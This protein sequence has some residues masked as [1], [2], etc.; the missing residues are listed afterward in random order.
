MKTLVLDKPATAELF[1]IR[2]LQGA[3]FQDPLY[4]GHSWG[5]KHPWKGTAEQAV[6]IA[7]CY[8]HPCEILTA[9]DLQS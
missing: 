5:G 1:V 2:N 7:Q 9:S 6:K 8:K 4:A 3:F